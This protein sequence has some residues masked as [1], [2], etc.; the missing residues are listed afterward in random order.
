MAGTAAVILLVIAITG[1]EPPVQTPRSPA[2]RPETATPASP[3]LVQRFQQELAE[4]ERQ[5]RADAA[6]QPAVAAPP[7]PPSAYTR[8]AGSTPQSVDEAHRAVDSLF[9]DNVVSSRRAAGETPAAPPRT[10]RVE[11]PPTPAP[12]DAPA[13]MASQFARLEQMTSDLAA[14]RSAGGVPSHAA[15]LSPPPAAAETASPT[16]ATTGAPHKPSTTEYPADGPRLRLSEGTVIETVLVTRL[17]GT[18]SGP[19][20][21]QVTT[22]VY[23]ADRQH[24]V[25]PQG[26]RVI[27]ASAAVQ[28][29]GDTRLAV[30]FHRLLLP[31]GHTYSLDTFKALDQVGESGVTED[32]NRHYLQ[33]FGASVAIGA[34]SGLSQ[35]G[36]VTSGLG[37]TSFGDEYRQSAGAGLASATT[38]ILDRY[39]NVLPTITVREG[40]RLKVY[41][42]GD[43]ELPAYAPVTESRSGSGGLR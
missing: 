20:V 39:L 16:P 26:A 10:G 15:S 33:L 25:I 36:T 35:L 7:T 23:S 19:V 38:R 43:L 32:V 18:L 31:D 30:S 24:V 6:T 9:A 37:Q 22:P 40:Y 41:L 27:G 3:A 21:C 28:G 1:H 14:A 42:S 5:Q 34:L 8:P 4:R 29:W 2:S 12:T 17:N 13:N 11:R